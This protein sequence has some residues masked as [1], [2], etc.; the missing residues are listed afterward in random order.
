M[1]DRKADLDAE[2]SAAMEVEI[3]PALSDFA[4]AA[5]TRLGYLHPRATFNVRDHVIV[6]EGA[7][8]DAP[9]MRRDV[10]H[11]LYRERISDRGEDLRTRLIEGLLSR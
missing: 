8:G 9:T 5:V 3:E 1:A 4:G 11:A 2:N 10:L 6:V 7:I